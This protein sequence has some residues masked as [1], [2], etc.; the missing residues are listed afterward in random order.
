MSGLS[1]DPIWH[2][3]RDA[4]TSDLLIHSL[5]M[6]LASTMYSVEE[7]TVNFCVVQSRL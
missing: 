6:H 2:G 7:K 4:L 1:R 5:N 3:K